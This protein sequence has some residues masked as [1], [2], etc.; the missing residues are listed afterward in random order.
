[1]TVVKIIY[2]EDA[3]DDIE[4]WKRH[5]PQKYNKIRSLIKNIQQTPFSGL[6]KPEPLQYLYAGLWSRRIDKEHR[7][8][9]G[10]ENKVIKI[11]QCRFHYSK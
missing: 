10:I 9:Y 5:A 7:L 3:V 8:V 6:G 2:A 1:M 4:Y 11:Y